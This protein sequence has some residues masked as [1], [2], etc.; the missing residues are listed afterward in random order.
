MLRFIGSFLDG[1]FN[2]WLSEVETLT[3]L[4]LAL[5]GAIVEVSIPH[6]GFAFVSAGAVVAAVAAYFGLG[7]IAQIGL[8]VV[9][10]VVSLVGLRS[11]LVGYLGGQGVP[12]RTATLVGKH[13]VV[14]HDIDATLGAGRVNVGG[15][16]WAARAHEP[17]AIGVKVR[18]V[19]A[20][21]IVLEVT[22]A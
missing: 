15:E 9:V 21:G 13:G 2:S 5:V 7:L 6:F 17:I 3:W 16:D 8:F 18:V 10:L 14:T 1:V 19:S 4:G 22:R 11:R 20:D 12:S